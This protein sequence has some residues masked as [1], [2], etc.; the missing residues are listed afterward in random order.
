MKLYLKGNYE[1]SIYQNCMEFPWKMWFKER[2][3]VEVGFSYARDDDF[4]F[5]VSL[6]KFSSNDERW[7]V[8]DFKIGDNPW[9]SFKYEYLILDFEDSYESDGREKGNYLRIISTHLDIL[10]V[11]K[12]A[13]YI[14]AIEVASAIDGQISED[15]KETWLS[16]EEFKTKHK[17]LLNLTY[18]EAVDISLEELEVMEAIDE[19][20]WDELHR[21]W[22][23]YIKIHGERVY[24]DEEDE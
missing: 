13:L 1:T 7:G 2:K 20:L 24:D 17:D 18:D 3:G 10:T 22:E 15:D 5:S 21:G 19:P 4:Y 12:R 14:M 6:D 9:N 16:I 8:T 23:E 11:D